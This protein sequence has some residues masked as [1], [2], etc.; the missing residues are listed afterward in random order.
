[1]M[2]N[3]IAYQIMFDDFQM[4]IKSPNLYTISFIIYHCNPCDTC[5]NKR[6]SDMTQLSFDDNK[7]INI[8]Q[9]ILIIYSSVQIYK[10]K[11][12]IFYKYTGG[13]EMGSKF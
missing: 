10:L 9:G 6:G 8:Q 5:W 13:S 4:Q 3:S 12:Y 1:M 2:L 11:F 7:G